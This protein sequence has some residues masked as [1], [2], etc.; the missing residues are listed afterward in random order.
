MF[1]GNAFYNCII[2]FFIFKRKISLSVWIS[3]IL[4]AIGIV[5]M[6]ALG[7]KNTG[8]IMD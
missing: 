8:S 5:I 1:S 3:I 2:K 6:A 7:N 4:A